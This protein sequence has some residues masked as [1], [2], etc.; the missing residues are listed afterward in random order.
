MCSFVK[1]HWEWLTGFLVSLMGVIITIKAYRYA[2][3]ANED[4]N[5][6]IKQSVIDAVGRRS[7]EEIRDRIIHT[8]LSEWRLKGQAV[9]YLRWEYNRLKD[10]GWTSDDFEQIYVEVGQRYKGRLPKQKLFQG[11]I[12]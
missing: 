7:K 1:Q 9:E 2:K 3:R 8:A 12:E 6:L 5:V 10:N 4:T 11:Q